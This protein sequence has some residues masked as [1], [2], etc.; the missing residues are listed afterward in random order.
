MASVN[1]PALVQQLD[2]TKERWGCRGKVH[3]NFLRAGLGIYNGKTCTYAVRLGSAVDVVALTWRLTLA[4]VTAVERR[5]QHRN[6][7]RPP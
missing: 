5:T 6:C 7:E 4:A 1:R 3:N 2:S